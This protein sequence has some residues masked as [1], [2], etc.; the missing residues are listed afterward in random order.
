MVDAHVRSTPT[1]ST[2]NTVVVVVGV[3]DFTCI[4]TCKF[5]CPEDEVEN[6]LSNVVPDTPDF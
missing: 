3:D 5:H 1:T 6:T 2:F 4:F